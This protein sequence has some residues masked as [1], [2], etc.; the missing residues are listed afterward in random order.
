MWNKY[1]GTI[2][3]TLNSQVTCERKNDTTVRFLFHLLLKSLNS[4]S[5]TQMDFSV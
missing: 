4:Q 5:D 1:K 2:L 3:K